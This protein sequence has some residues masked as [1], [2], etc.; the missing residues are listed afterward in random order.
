MASAAFMQILIGLLIV[1][2]DISLNGVDVLFD[3]VG[4]VLIFAGCSKLETQSREFVPAK[5]GAAVAG[6]VSFL[7]ALDIA[8]AADFVSAGISACD[9]MTTWFVCSGIIRMALA[10]GQA[11]FA[12]IMTNVRLWSL[13]VGIVA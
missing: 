5:V 2:I 6:I 7:Q 12:H 10:R 1:A 4:Y 11:E 9:I 8:P 13:I 3:L